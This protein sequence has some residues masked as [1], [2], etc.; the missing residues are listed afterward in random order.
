MID[1]IVISLME[2]GNVDVKFPENHFSKRYLMRILKALKLEYRRNVREYRKQIMKGVKNGKNTRRNSSTGINIGEGAGGVK[3]EGTAN[4]IGNRGL[5]KS[6]ELSKDRRVEK[7][8]GGK[9]SG[10][11]KT[12]ARS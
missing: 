3:A 12:T 4:V 11:A 1:K 2:D 8:V 9:R 5:K 6:V 7:V 10:D